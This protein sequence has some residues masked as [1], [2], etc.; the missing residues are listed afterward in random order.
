MENNLE[1][2]DNSAIS[3]SSMDLILAPEHD[4]HGVDKR[5]EKDVSDMWRERHG[6]SGWH[7]SH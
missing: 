6:P 5:S 2:Q 1:A 7:V 4:H 3:Q